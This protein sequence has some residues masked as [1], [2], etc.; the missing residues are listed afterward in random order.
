V[1]EVDIPFMRRRVYLSHSENRMERNKTK[2]K[3]IRKT[4]SGVQRLIPLSNRKER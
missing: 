3:T 1:R 2:E 4:P